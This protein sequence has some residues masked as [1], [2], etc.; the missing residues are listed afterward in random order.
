MLYPGREIRILRSTEA[1]R[2]VSL[3]LIVQSSN[4]LFK[5]FFSFISSTSIGAWYCRITHTASGLSNYFTYP[6]NTATNGQSIVTSTFYM[7]C[8]PKSTNLSQYENCTGQQSESYYPPQYQRMPFRNGR[9]LSSSPPTFTASRLFSQPAIK[10]C[11]QK[12]AGQYAVTFNLTSP[13]KI[14]DQDAYILYRNGFFYV[15]CS[16]ENSRDV[17]CS[18]LLGVWD[19]ND[20]NGDLL[21]SRT[22][23][24]YPPADNATALIYYSRTK[25][26]CTKNRCAGG[27]S[28]AGFPLQLPVNGKFSGA[29][30]ITILG[31]LTLRKLPLQ[32]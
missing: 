16:G 2:W 13:S 5:I 32:N 31:S 30:S 25:L 3:W 8:P 22:Y 17:P 20:T 19:C 23:F 4:G 14:V 18:N 27:F 6:A 9:P 10:S 7:Q 24:K 21:I 15:A 11:H 28:V 29:P 1:H 26:T 12:Y